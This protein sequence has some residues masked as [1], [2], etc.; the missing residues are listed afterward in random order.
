MSPKE[1]QIRR[2]LILRGPTG[3]PREAALK[4]GFGS[5]DSQAASGKGGRF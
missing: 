3:L 5:T 1:E 4:G 2:R